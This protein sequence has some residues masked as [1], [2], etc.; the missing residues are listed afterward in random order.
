MSTLT[1]LSS[2]SARQRG[3]TLIVA[4]VILVVMSV[5]G[6]ASMTS[7]NLQ[8]RM[9]S[10]EKQQLMAQYAADA[11]VRAAK[12][13]LDA[14]VKDKIK[15]AKFNGGI[16]GLY[17]ST[18]EN[19]VGLTWPPASVDAGFPDYMKGPQW[20]NSNS[21]E[22]VPDTEGL[23]A[24]ILSSRYIIEFVGQENIGGSIVIDPTK[25]NQRQE[26]FIF[27]ITAVGWGQDTRI[28]SIVQSTYRTAAAGDFSY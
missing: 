20:E 16:K 15:L 19:S 2:F 10:N 12:L 8:A 26:P 7:S 18:A 27:K 28:Y 4:L 13:Y 14:N 9:A 17:A 25:P 5:V 6:I 23:P 3:V 24:S 1:F 11:G 21:V 22:V